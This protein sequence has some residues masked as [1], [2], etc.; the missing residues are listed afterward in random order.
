MHHGLREWGPPRARLS[1]RKR[2]SPPTRFMPPKAYG[3]LSGV[4]PRRRIHQHTPPPCL[5]CVRC[6]Q[7]L[8]IT[9]KSKVIAP[10]AALPALCTHPA[11]VHS[12]VLSPWVRSPPLLGPP[13]TGFPGHATSSTPLPLHSPLS[14]PAP[15][16]FQVTSRTRTNLVTVTWLEIYQNVNCTYLRGSGWGG[17]R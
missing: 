13:P 14:V 6:V 12:G 2:Q 15:S 1:A 9:V 8:G 16:N 17:T 11:Q 3:V 7:G 5:Q 4:I 10:T